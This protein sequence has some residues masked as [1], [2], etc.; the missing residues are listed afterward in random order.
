[1]KGLLMKDT[2]LRPGY[3]PPERLIEREGKGE[4]LV[5]DTVL[6]LMGSGVGRELTKTEQAEPVNF[7]RIGVVMKQRSKPALI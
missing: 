6:D 5:A 2:R 4:A 3:E 7:Q 1:M